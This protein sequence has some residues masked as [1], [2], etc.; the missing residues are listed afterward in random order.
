MGGDELIPTCSFGDKLQ[1]DGGFVSFCPCGPENEIVPSKRTGTD[2]DRRSSNDR[3]WDENRLRDVVIDEEFDGE[4]SVSFQGQ[5]GKSYSRSKSDCCVGFGKTGTYLGNER[6]DC[7]EIDVVGFLSKSWNMKMEISTFG[8]DVLD[9]NERRCACHSFSGQY[10][11]ICFHMLV[12]D[13][14]F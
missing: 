6:S 12:V 9:R 3:D 4:G 13:T 14:P 8:N 11:F 2:F 5:D 7:D 1:N 10:G